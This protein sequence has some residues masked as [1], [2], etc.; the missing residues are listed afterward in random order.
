MRRL[1][2]S[3]VGRG[4]LGGWITLSIGVSWIASSPSSNARWKISPDFPSPC[5]C[6]YANAIKILSC[7]GFWLDNATMSTLQGGCRSKGK[8][9]ASWQF[10][11]V[12]LISWSSFSAPL[13]DKIRTC[14]LRSSCGGLTKIGFSVP[15]PQT[16]ALRIG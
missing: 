11:I 15:W 5:E 16:A 12:F 4:V 1:L 2:S 13:V 3:G 8:N 10:N 6:E 7:L 14:C 9:G